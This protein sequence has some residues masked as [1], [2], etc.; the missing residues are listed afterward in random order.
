MRGRWQSSHINSMRCWLQ[1]SQLWLVEWG[2]NGLKN[3]PK[4]L[5][6]VKER[7]IS[8]RKTVQMWGLI[9]KKS[10]LQVRKKRGEW[11]LTVGRA[12]SSFFSKK[13]K[14]TRLLELANHP[15]RVP[16]ISEKV[17]RQGSKNYTIKGYQAR[18]AALEF[19]HFFYPFPFY[20]RV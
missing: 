18:K 13:E 4:G 12:P 2:F 8:A 3:S 20:F 11:P 5:R 16:Y 1:I 10:T 14:K 15:G 7:G 19:H 6:D 9:M 17:P